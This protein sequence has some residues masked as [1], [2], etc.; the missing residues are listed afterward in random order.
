MRNLSIFRKSMLAA[1]VTM[2]F[3]AVPF[4]QAMA[5][6]AMS[7]PQSSSSRSSDES[8]S[9]KTHDAWITTKVKSEL[10]GAKHVKST[11]ISVTTTKGVV[12]LSGTVTST[13][14][15]NHVVHVAKKVKG[16]KSVDA[17]ALTVAAASSSSNGNN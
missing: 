13:K 17:S 11:D 4:S 15:K 5:L 7:S 12:A 6:D 16:V 3:A 9:A 1:G 14:E 10:A 2:V 8:M